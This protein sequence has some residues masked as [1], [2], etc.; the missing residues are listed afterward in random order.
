[1]KRLK[2]AWAE[3]DHNIVHFVS[4]TL[5]SMVEE[6][7]V[8]LRLFAWCQAAQETFFFVEDLGDE[9]GVE[10]GNSALVKASKN[11]LRR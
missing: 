6:S 4:A 8:T 1:M 10:N 7:T 3:S 11:A 2:H 5:G 9:A